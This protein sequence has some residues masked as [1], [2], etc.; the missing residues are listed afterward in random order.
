MLGSCH[1]VLLPNSTAIPI[2][3]SLGGHSQLQ[4]LQGHSQPQ[5][6]Y[7]VVLA[8]ER[9]QF[10]QQKATLER[11]WHRSQ[12][13]HPDAFHRAWQRANFHRADYEYVTSEGDTHTGVVQC[14]TWA[15][16]C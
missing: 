8:H 15:A 9:A 11:H 5:Q 16:V 14:T 10:I 4:H 2:P 3:W 6:L 13:L 12:S 7:P 1:L